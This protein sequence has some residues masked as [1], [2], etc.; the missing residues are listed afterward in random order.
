M[1][2]DYSKEIYDKYYNIKNRILVI[3]LN[4]N[5]I[6]EGALV[7]FIHGDSDDP[8]IIKWHF[9]DKEELEA[10]HQGLDVSIEGNQD[11]GKIIRQKDIKNVRF[12]E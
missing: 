1:T 11:K 4:D 5:T 8:F 7:S 9:I 2:T 10:F 6:L 12:K 3:T